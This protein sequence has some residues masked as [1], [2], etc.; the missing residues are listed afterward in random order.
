MVVSNGEKVSKE[1]I[2]TVKGSIVS[3]D[4]NY[5]EDVVITNVNVTP[6][7]QCNLLS[8]TPLMR[9]G[10]KLEG[11]GDTLSLTKGK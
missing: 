7:T 9:D 4:G 5:I 6:K 11:K 10:W 3:N 2:G 1:R 8:I